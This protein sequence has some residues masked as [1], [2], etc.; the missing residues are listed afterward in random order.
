MEANLAG[1]FFCA[2][3]GASDVEPAPAHGWTANSKWSRLDQQNDALTLELDRPVMGARITK[4][5]KL[6][7]D[8]PLLYQSHKFHGGAGRLPVAH[9]VMIHF[10]T[11]ATYSTS[12][13]RAAITPKTPLENGRHRLAIDARNDDITNFPAQ[14]GTSV[15]LRSLPIGNAHEDFV[16]LLEAEDAPLGWSAVIREAEDDIVF[17]LKDPAT[18]PVTMLWHSNGGRDYAPWNGRHRNVLGIEDGCAAGPDGHSAALEASR[19]AQDG[20]ATTISLGQT[21]RIS[22]VIGA[23]PRPTGWTQVAGIGAQDG[24]LIITN[25]N[26]E[27]HSMPFE[28]DFLTKDS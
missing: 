15:D 28:T 22:H 5:L 8:A 16:T 2:P 18:L 7:Q 27:T 24:Q 25:V 17:V 9:H 4:C 12:T 26:G 6:A 3:F 10:A 21:V 20:V 13:K 14:D 11:R 23:I 1:D 19:V